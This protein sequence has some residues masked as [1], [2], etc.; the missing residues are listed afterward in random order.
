MALPRVT[1]ILKSHGFY[2]VFDNPNID[3]QAAMQRGRYVDMACNILA[4]YGHLEDGWI[5]RHPECSLYVAAY[6]KFLTEHRFKMID[7]QF[8]VVNEVE[9]Y[10]GHPDEFGELD[11]NPFCLLSLKTGSMPK[12][13][14]L[15][16]AAYVAGMR[17]HAK[18]RDIGRIRRAWVQLKP[19]GNYRFGY[20]DDP[21]DFDNWAL[22]VRSFWIKNKYFEV[23]V[24]A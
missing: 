8:E 17:T 10:V 9:R 24:D 20:F 21:A 6:R 16:E 13:N 22:L 23:V 5:D 1:H 12:W 4:A 14:A 11:D 19:D 2:D 18:Y 7:C 15:Q 3:S